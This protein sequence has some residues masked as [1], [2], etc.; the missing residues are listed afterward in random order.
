MAAV[1]VL[2]CTGI[3]YAVREYFWKQNEEVVKRITGFNGEVYL[4]SE[5]MKSMKQMYKS[6]G[7]ADK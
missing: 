4:S 5:G 6:R 3:D 7:N 1:A 2:G